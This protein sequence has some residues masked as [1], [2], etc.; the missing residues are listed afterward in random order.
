MLSVSISSPAGA[1]EP[2]HMLQ[3]VISCPKTLVAGFD[4]YN[5]RLRGDV[6]QCLP[7]FNLCEY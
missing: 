5:S 1:V 6:D 3:Q 7:V 4:P 2:M